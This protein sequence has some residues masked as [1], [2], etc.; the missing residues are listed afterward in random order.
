MKNSKNTT[1]LVFTGIIVLALILTFVFFT[2]N[3]GKT[4]D[5]IDTEKATKQ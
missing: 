3:W 5:T 2:Q 1:I 4:K